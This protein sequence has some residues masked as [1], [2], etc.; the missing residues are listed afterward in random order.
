MLVDVL[1][2][3][4][5]WTPCAPPQDVSH[6]KSY[7]WH[8]QRL[9][10]WQ[11]LQG[12]CARRANYISELLWPLEIMLFSR[13]AWNC[14]YHVNLNCCGRSVIVFVWLWVL[15][16]CDCIF[17]ICVSGGRCIWCVCGNDCI[18]AASQVNLDSQLIIRDSSKVIVLLSP[19]QHL[20]SQAN[21]KLLKQYE[22]GV[23]S[24][25]VNPS[26]RKQF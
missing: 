2:A 21:S 10:F 16:L 26:S 6:S 13:Y 23:N 8:R 9:Y 4:H 19:S 18:A 3:C 25:T 20:P 1:S 11:W 14:P 22:S 12:I 17:N 15:Y 7:L 24:Y 5:L